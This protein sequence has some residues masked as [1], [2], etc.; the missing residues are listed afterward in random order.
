MV[1]KIIDI[2]H[3]VH[4][5]ESNPKAMAPCLTPADGDGTRDEELLQQRQMYAYQWHSENAPGV[6]LLK[7]LPLR[8]FFSPKY[9][10]L[11]GAEIAKIG[12]NHELSE[13]GAPDKAS[14][15]AQVNHL[16][17]TLDTPASAEQSWW[18][19]DESFGEQRLSG[20]NPVLLQ[21]VTSEQQLGL[22]EG[23]A[24]H[25]DA[26]FQQVRGCLRDDNLYVVDHVHIL[27]NCTSDRIDGKRL[28]KTA[29]LFWYNKW[30]ERLLPLAIRIDD[31]VVTAKDTQRWLH[32]KLGFQAADGVVHEMRSHLGQT[33]LVM[34]ACAI[35]MKRNLHAR[36]PVSCLLTPHFRFMLALNNTAEKTLI[37]PGSDVAN[38]FG[39]P[40][41]QV[42]GVAKDAFDSFS[43]HDAALPRQ[44]QL[45]G[46]DNVKKLPHY[47]YRDDALLLWEAIVD[48]VHHTLGLY[49]DEAHFALDVESRRWLEELGRS[50]DDDGA[51]L[52]GVQ[53]PTTLAEYVEL[54]ATMVF[55]CSAQH[56]AVNFTQY[57]YLAY[58]PNSSFAL[59]ADPDDVDF[60]QNLPPLEPARGQ[61]GTLRQ[62]T[63]FRYDVLGDYAHKYTTDPDANH[64]IAVFQKRLAA[65]EEEIGKRNQLRWRTY[66]V[67]RPSLV[68]NS[69]S[70]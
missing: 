34:G 58:P 39:L 6:P 3:P 52:G 40:I 64:A 41:A 27:E 19:T 22:F 68:T 54:V 10:I 30:D 23:L 4:T 61:I 59:W 32:A 29:A 35:A 36:H 69:I 65:V 15:L 11:S 56:S 37:A 25:D 53:V 46:V 13:L 51:G 12:I 7:E 9:L 26:V 48:Y 2:D 24:A 28:P 47:P 14:S 45:R 20:A 21:R 17:V 55:T 8:E 60:L 50:A 18:A 66:E 33:H 67:L 49:Y 42:V 5:E 57:A 63:A 43:L 44:L 31:E 16:Y 62:L 70:I 1:Q 38:S